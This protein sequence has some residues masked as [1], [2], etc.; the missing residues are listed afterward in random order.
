MAVET[1]PRVVNNPEQRRYELW[2]GA[3]C[4][5]FIDYLSEPGT[6]LLIHTRSRPHL[7]GT[8]ARRTAG[9]GALADLGA[10]DLKVV[11]L[12]RSSAPTCAATLSTQTWSSATGPH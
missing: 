6:I 10:R 2:L 12:C 8:G 3:T 5:G 1:D 7:R 11:P 4:A 9:A